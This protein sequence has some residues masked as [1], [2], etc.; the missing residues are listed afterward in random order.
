MSR[1]RRNGA[2]FRRAQSAAPMV[3]YAMAPAPALAIEQEGDRRDE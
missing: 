3:E 1:E 2:V